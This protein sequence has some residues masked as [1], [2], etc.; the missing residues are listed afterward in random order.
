M[1]NVI[2]LDE[3]RKK[4]YEKK[5]EEI[6]KKIIEKCDHLYTGKTEDYE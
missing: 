2:S 4:K 6:M 1:S 3:Y 5:N